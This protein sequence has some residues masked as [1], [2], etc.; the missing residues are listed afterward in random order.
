MGSLRSLQSTPQ[1]SGFPPW[2]IKLVSPLRQR[3]FSFDIP[4]NLRKE[5]ICTYVIAEFR[6]EDFIERITEGIYVTRTEHPDSREI[7]MVRYHTLI[8]GHWHPS[9]DC[10]APGRWHYSYNAEYSEYELMVNG[11]DKFLRDGRYSVATNGPC[12]IKPIFNNMLHGK[13]IIEILKNNCNL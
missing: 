10:D 12:F 4:D 13:E 6:E 7:F 3:G 8:D 9:M 1:L 2:L 11:L 5:V